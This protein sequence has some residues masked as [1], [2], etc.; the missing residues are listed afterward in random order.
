MRSYFRLPSAIL[1]ASDLSSREFA[2]LA[3]LLSIHTAIRSGN[4]AEYKRVRQAIIA[5]KCGMSAQTVARVTASLLKKGYISAIID[6]YRN[7]RFTGTY[8]YV[9]NLSVRSWGNYALVSREIFGKLSPV[10]LRVYCFML[11]AEDKKLGYSWNSFKDISTAIHISRNT[12][13]SAIKQLVELG[14]IKRIHRRRRD[15]ERVYADNC[16]MVIVVTRVAMGIK[17][18]ARLRRALLL[19]L[20]SHIRTITKR[21]VNVNHIHINTHSR[22][23]QGVIGK[24]RLFSFTR[25]SPKNKDLYITHSYYNEKRTTIW[26]YLR[27]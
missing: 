1:Y 23:C 22:D 4:G 16:Y 11:G 20:T 18:E 13:I 9:I 10:Q 17:K 15:N 25:G 14:M 12:A 2:V 7:N 24:K 3:Y 5:E 6:S 27:I 21:Y 8:T 19:I 26:L